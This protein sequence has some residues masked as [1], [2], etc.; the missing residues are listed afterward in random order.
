MEQI[1]LEALVRHQ[2]GKGAARTLRRAG[3]VPAIFYGPDSP[4]L[5]L[6]IHRLDLEKIFK[7]HPGENIFFELQIKGGEQDIT[8]TALLKELQRHPV[9]R[10]YLHSDFF[11]ISLTKELDVDVRIRIVGKSPGVEKGGLLQEVTRELQ[12]RCLPGMIPEFIDVDVSAL[13]IGEAIHVRDLQ[14]AEGIKILTELQ[15]TLL[16]VVPPLGEKTTEEEGEAPG[17]VEVVS[18]KGKPQDAG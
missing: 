10:A 2:T 9:S 14:L 16:N 7:K 8:K 12:I 18:K 13:E 5:P 4:P 15:A 11:E 17:E 1:Q 3:E 6:T